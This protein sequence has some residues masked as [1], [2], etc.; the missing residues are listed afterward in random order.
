MKKLIF[1]ILFSF[2]FSSFSHAAPTCKQMKSCAE[3]K[4]YLK[5]GH[6]RLDRD[7][8]GVPCENIC[9]GG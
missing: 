7:K 1:F 6:K 2:F 9:P 8:D 3:A 4:K 5:Q